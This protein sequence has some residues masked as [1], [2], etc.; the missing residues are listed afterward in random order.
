MDNG[1]HRPADALR[2]QKRSDEQQ[3]NQGSGQCQFKPDALPYFGKHGI[4]GRTDQHHPI[5]SRHRSVA[6]QLSFVIGIPDESG[7]TR[8]D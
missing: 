8:F 2:D 3:G 5:G 7:V 6:I 1:L 4:L